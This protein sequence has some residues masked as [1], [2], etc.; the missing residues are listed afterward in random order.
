MTETKPDSIRWV[1]RF[2]N[3][4]RAFTRLREALDRLEAG[5]LDDLHREGIIQRFEYTWELAW[6]TLKDFLQFKKVTLT[7]ITAA[8]VI[9]TAFAANYI[10]DGQDWMDALDARNEMSHVYSE[11][12]F[13]RIVKDIVERYFKLFE[14]LYDMLIAERVSLDRAE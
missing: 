12:A 5:E 1:Q 7:H 10:N 3:Y 13:N 8:E 6:K 4:G 14:D 2:Q 9:K 11:E